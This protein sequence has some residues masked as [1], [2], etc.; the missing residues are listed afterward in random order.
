MHPLFKN[1][2]FVTLF[3]GRLVTNAGDSLYFVAAMWLVYS[4]TGSEFYTGLAGFL[5][6]A[7]SAFQA[8][9]G[10]L[11]DRW[12]LRRLLV[13]SQLIQATLVCVVPLA[14]YTGQLTVWVVL[15]VMPLLTLLNQ[16]VYPAQT[17]AL[18]R[19]VDQDE[20]VAA[21]SAFSLAYQGVDMAFNAVGGVL[22]GLVGAITIYLA[23]S[24]TFVAAALLF[25][26]LAIPEAGAGD[27]EGDPGDSPAEM[28]DPAPSGDAPVADG[29]VSAA[30]AEPDGDTTASS[31]GYLADLREGVDHLRGTV[32]SRMIGGSVVVNF[33]FGMAIAVLPSYGAQLGGAGVYGFLMAAVAGG[34]FV[35]AILANVVEGLPFGRLSVGSMALGGVAWLAGVSLGWTPGTALLL[36][37]ATVPA[38]VTNVLIS[39]LVQT[40]VPDRLL[41]RVSGVLGTASALSVPFGSLLGGTLAGTFGATTVMYVAGGGFL[42]LAAYV[43][44]VPSLRRMPAVGDVE[45]L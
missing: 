4:L 13:V 27:V 37:A 29:G 20:L 44:A 40:M 15:A 16:F 19:L 32:L 30:E 7:P 35:G 8:F 23:D 24:V 33:T 18:P 26:T 17:A 28:A 39:S 1:R 42:F 43:A 14:Y 22:V 3:T 2:N 25:V 38:G 6:M 12:D 21:N 41:G 31:S 45:T 9:A 36:A 34:M 5:T 11:V 10:P